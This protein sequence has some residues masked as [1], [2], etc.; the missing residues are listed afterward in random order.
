MSDNQDRLERFRRARLVRLDHTLRPLAARGAEADVALVVNTLCA[1]GHRVTFSIVPSE[2]KEAFSVSPPDLG[3][4]R[5]TT[6]EGR[7]LL[8]TGRCANC[9]PDPPGDQ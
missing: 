2:W 7:F 9:P 6:S 4:L 5:S 3:A 1:S 8:R